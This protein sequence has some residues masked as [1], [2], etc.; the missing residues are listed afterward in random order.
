MVG[1]FYC[2]WMFGGGNKRERE[3]KSGYIKRKKSEI[4]R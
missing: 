1:S 3:I 2:L 4:N